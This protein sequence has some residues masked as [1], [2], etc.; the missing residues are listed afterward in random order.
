MC[1][2]WV[3]YTDAWLRTVGP[4]LDLSKAAGD[5][6][7]YLITAT[8]QATAT[9]GGCPKVWH[10]STRGCTGITSGA[11]AAVARGCPALTHLDLAHSDV[12]DEGLIAF[13]HAGGVARL[14]EL[15]ITGC[16]HLSSASITAAASA[17]VKLTTLIATQCI[18]V[19]SAALSNIVAAA[20]HLVEVRVDLAAISRDE[21]AR[22]AAVGQGKHVVDVCSFD[23]D[24]IAASMCCLVLA[25]E[26]GGACM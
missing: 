12:N 14:Q 24:D 21:M 1:K 2:D 8:L 6:D 17:C 18:A 10:L 15:D 9:G 7:P 26:E 19:D 3:A 25:D 13:L 5:T 4:S 20:H 11:L 23:G 22:V 16:N